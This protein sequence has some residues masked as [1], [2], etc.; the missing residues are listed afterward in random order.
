MY[1][2]CRIELAIA[3]ACRSKQQKHEQ[4]P[5][6][7]CERIFRCYVRRTARWNW[8]TLCAHN[9]QFSINYRAAQLT[10]SSL[11]SLLWCWRSRYWISFCLFPSKEIGRVDTSGFGSCCI[12]NCHCASACSVPS[13]VQCTRRYIMQFTTSIWISNTIWLS[14]TYPLC[15]THWFWHDWKWKR[16]YVRH[17]LRE[18]DRVT[19]FNNDV[20]RSIEC[21][22]LIFSVIVFVCRLK[23][24]KNFHEIN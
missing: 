10:L 16:Y 22:K 21:G 3:S 18:A 19:G 14:S 23:I 6:L 17:L 2:G 9:E 1:Y 13:T 15:R 7:Y 12:T 4:E 8:L 11:N 24:K 5:I 20:H